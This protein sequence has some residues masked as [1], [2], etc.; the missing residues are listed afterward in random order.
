LKI[1]NKE[2][3]QLRQLMEETAADKAAAK[4]RQEEQRQA[5]AR[6]EAAERAAR[7]HEAYERQQQA[8]LMEERRR[9]EE[10]RL[11]EQ[12]RVELERQRERLRLKEEA[13]RQAAAKLQ[14]ETEDLLVR[15]FLE[16]HGFEGINQIRKIPSGF[17]RSRKC[18]PLH[19]AVEHNEA[20]LVRLLVSRGADVKAKNGKGK[21]PFDLAQGLGQENSDSQGL[22]EL[23][24]PK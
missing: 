14:I 21:R 7:E 10:A 16:K 24:Q 8:L 2:V 23:L 19:L 5:D 18:S 4:A 17:M 12:S 3:D 1:E 20:H 9:A 13:D 6:R 15:D 11:Q 22:L